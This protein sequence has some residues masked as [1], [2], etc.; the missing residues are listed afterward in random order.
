MTFTDESSALHDNLSLRL[1]LKFDTD[2]FSETT[3]KEMVDDF[4]EYYIKKN[5]PNILVPIRVCRDTRK[6]S[7]QQRKQIISTY[8]SLYA[9]Q[10]GGGK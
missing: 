6:E 7:V 4:L 9:S 10:D 8:W 5:V 2:I 1:N 3:I